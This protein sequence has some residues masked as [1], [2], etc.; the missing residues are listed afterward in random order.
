MLI[1]FLILM[2]AVSAIDITNYVR[3]PRNIDVEFSDSLPIIEYNYTLSEDVSGCKINYGD[4][5]WICL[6]SN[7]CPVEKGYFV[8]QAKEGVN[9]VNID[10][11][12][13]NNNHAYIEDNF[14]T[15]KVTAK[16]KASVKY[17]NINSWIILVISTFI[18]SLALWKTTKILNF[19]DYY[20]R[21]AIFL[22]IVIGIINFILQN[23]LSFWIVIALL[24]PITVVLIKYGYDDDWKQAIIASIVYVLGLGLFNFLF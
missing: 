6:K 15:S 5:S 10:C 19:I 3:T 1:I 18:M 4:E 13:I 22:A 2:T 23:F 14:T 17:A 8:T 7:N 11:W 9:M 16:V 20:Y 24:F 21:Y 12:D